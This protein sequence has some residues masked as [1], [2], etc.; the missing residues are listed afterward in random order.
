MPA[1]FGF[2]SICGGGCGEGGDIGAGARGIGTA[3]RDEDEVAR[4][5]P[6]NLVSEVGGP[7]SKNLVSG[8]LSGS[9]DAAAR[10]MPKP[11][12]TWPPPAFTGMDMG[13]NVVA[14]VGIVGGADGIDIGGGPGVVAVMVAP[15]MDMRVDAMG[16]MGAPIGGKGIP[17]GVPM[18]GPAG[19]MGGAMGATM[20]AANAAIGAIGAIGAAM[21]TPVPCTVSGIGNSAGGGAPGGAVD[22]VGAA[23][24]WPPW[25]AGPVAG[26]GAVA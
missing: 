4:V 18:G 8:P 19:A 2:T 9:S 10:N 20:G 21:G 16:A 6:E 1:F 13:S 7:L 25:A 17:R 26:A 24:V 22:T 11:D 23:A 12:T 15:F 14:M 3:P 5:T